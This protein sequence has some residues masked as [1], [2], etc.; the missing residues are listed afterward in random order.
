MPR[1]AGT[2]TLGALAKHA[3]ALRFSCPC[4]H[5]GEVPIAE[6]TMRHPWATSIAEIASRAKCSACGGREVTLKPV[7]RDVLAA[8]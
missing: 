4:G 5:V 2:D 1:R 7:W 6:L 8:G 3:D